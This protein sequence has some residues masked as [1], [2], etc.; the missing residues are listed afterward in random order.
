MDKLPKHRMEEAKEK[1]REKLSYECLI[2]LPR[3]R[4][5]TKKQYFVLIKNIE[6]ICQIMLEAYLESTKV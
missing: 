3:Y 1:L 2:K 6:S 4:N 5:L